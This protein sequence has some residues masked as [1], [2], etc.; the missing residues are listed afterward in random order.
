MLNATQKQCSQ[1]GEK[2]YRHGAEV[3]PYR[4]SPYGAAAEDKGHD[5]WRGL[6]RSVDGRAFW[7]SFLLWFEQDDIGGEWGSVRLRSP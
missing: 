4:R 1:S 6:H 7:G 3:A 5:D 2:R